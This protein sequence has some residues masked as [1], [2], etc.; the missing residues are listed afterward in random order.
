MRRV[1]RR[2]CFA[3]CRDGTLAVVRETSPGKFAVVQTVQTRPAPN[4]DVDPKT[5][6]L[7][8]PTAELPTTAQPGRPTPKPDS[9]MIV[10]AEPVK[11]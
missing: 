11:P 5:H 2:Q 6:M 7:Y 1:R 4:D 9:F 3:S 8:L 10:V